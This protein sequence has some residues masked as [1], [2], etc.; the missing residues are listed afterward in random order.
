MSLIKDPEEGG[1]H[2]M[3]KSV[4]VAECSCNKLQC[5]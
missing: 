2:A 5:I 4:G 3:R 1:S